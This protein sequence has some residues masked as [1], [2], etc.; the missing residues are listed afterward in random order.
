MWTL[1]FLKTE[2]KK[3]PFSKFPDTGEQSLSLLRQNFWDFFIVFEPKNNNKFQ[4]AK[5]QLYSYV[6]NES[7]LRNCEHLTY[8]QEC[9]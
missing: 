1:I 9:L 3:F 2:K 4:R 6:A 8:F 7:T 5:R